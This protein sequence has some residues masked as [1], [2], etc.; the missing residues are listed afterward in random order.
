LAGW[1]TDMTSS[2]TISTESTF[3]EDQQRFVASL[4]DDQPQWLQDFRKAG[5]ER[6]EKLGFPSHTDEDWRGTRLSRITEANFHWQAG[7]VQQLG[8][9]LLDAFEFYDLSCTRLV[10]VNG[11]YLPR[12]SHRR[13]LPFV[14]GVIAT[15]LA[16]ALKEY[17]DLI[18]PHLGKYLDTTDKPFAALNDAFIE[19]GSFIYIP[20]NT[21]LSEPLHLVYVTTPVSSEGHASFHP[22]NLI[23][24]EPGS[25]ATIIEDHV[26]LGDQPHFCNAVTEVFVD[27]NS[28]VEHYLLGRQNR[29]SPGV[30]TLAVRQKRDSHFASHSVSLGGSLVRNNFYPV[31]DGT[32]ADCLLNGLYV[33]GQD[34]HTDNHVRMVHGEPHCDSRQYFKGILD[35]NAKSVFTGRIVVQ[36]GAQKT[37]AKQSNSNLLLSDDTLVDS[38]PQLEIYADDVKCT[39]GA[40]VGQIDEDAIFYLRARGL[41]EPMARAMLIYAYAG[42]M[43]DL[44]AIESV[45]KTISDLVLRRLPHGKLLESLG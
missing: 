34:Q 3:I 42:E 20:K 4:G 36:P 27:E 10:F 21:K 18:E 8:S 29:Q 16:N 11:R 43:L 13:P 32:G 7:P 15:S 22:R 23:V 40:T 9:Q 17:S 37:D 1:V 14:E 12:P 19:D 41:S 31:L 25:D 44:M 28:R 2:T 38:K 26:S 24:T 45:R 33:G 5:I 35:H 6:F 39:H 30:N